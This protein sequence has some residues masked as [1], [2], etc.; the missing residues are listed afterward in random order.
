VALE[1]VHVLV[2]TCL[3]ILRLSLRRDAL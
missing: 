2:H 1:L 3:K